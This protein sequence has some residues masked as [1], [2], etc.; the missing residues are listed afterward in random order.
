MRTLGWRIAAN[1]SAI[2]IQA[3]T[4]FSLFCL[5]LIQ[6]IGKIHRKPWFLLAN[7]G[8]FQGFPVKSSH[9]IWP[10]DATKGP[11]RQQKRS[12]RPLGLQWRVAPCWSPQRHGGS[13]SEPHWKDW[14][15]KNHYLRSIEFRYDEYDKW[16]LIGIWI[17]ILILISITTNYWN[18]NMMSVDKWWL[19]HIGTEFRNSWDSSDAS[20]APRPSPGLFAG[21]DPVHQ[22]QPETCHWKCEQNIGLGGKCDSFCLMLKS[23]RTSKNMGPCG[24]V[25]KPW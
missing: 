2:P 12:V 3:R 16:I 7:F 23:P 21:Q 6:W 1:I 10:S 22:V 13:T 18:M 11:Q 14:N 17:W 19:E 9:Q 5:S 24:D 8:G 4:Q 15:E 20:T 25:S